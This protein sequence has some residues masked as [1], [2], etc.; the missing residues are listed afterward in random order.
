MAKALH[1]GTI[2]VP[3]PSSATV[4][5]GVHEK[6]N[7]PLARVDAIHARYRGDTPLFCV[8]AVQTFPY[9]TNV[10]VMMPASSSPAT[11]SGARS[12]IAGR[13]GSSGRL[14]AVA[15]M[16][17]TGTSIP[18]MRRSTAIRM[19]SRTGYRCGASR[20]SPHTALEGAVFVFVEHTLFHG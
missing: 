2:I 14:S 16:R 11:P 4:G 9:M 15:A 18:A 10:P 13:T 17:G 3:E 12:T 1:R 8:E 19:T 5:V 20:I 6:F 7:H